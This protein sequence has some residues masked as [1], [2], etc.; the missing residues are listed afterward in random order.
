MMR[1][2]NLLLL[3][4]FSA[5]LFAQAPVTTDREN[6]IQKRKVFQTANPQEDKVESTADLMVEKLNPVTSIKNQGMSGTC[7]CFSTTSLLESQFLK[8]NPG[9]DLNLSEMFVVRNIYREKAR[10]Y[11]LR[12]GHAQL[13]EGGLGHDVIRAISTYGAMPESAFAGFK[14]KINHSNIV[15]SLKQVLDSAIARDLNQSEIRMDWK[16]AVEKIL[17]REMG[18]PP[19]AFP[20]GDK[21]Y[22][23]KTFA[24]EVLKFNADDYVNITSFTDQPYY[25][26]FIIPVPDN[27]SNGQYINLPLDEMIDVTK[28]ALVNGYTVMW[29]ADVSNKG[30]SQKYGTALYLQPGSEI[31]SESSFGLAEAK[32]SPSVRQSLFENLTTQDDHLMHITGLEKTKSGRTFFLVKNSWGEVGPYKGFINVSEGYF[33]M[34]TISLIVPKAA[35][36]KAMRD[37][38][39]GR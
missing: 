3:S 8:S 10:N 28:T 18:T 20:Y 4:L 25:R 29:D 7:W 1:F 14:E 21:K 2:L 33:A 34:N 9:T 6:A 36:S 13:S 39:V 30:F 11:Y 26:P 35:L 12:Q 5:G 16:G 37:K 31:K 19:D 38:L 23:A 32:W 22:A 24:T 15:A 17:D 27:F